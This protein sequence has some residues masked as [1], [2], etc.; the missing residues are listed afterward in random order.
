MSQVRRINHIPAYGLQTVNVKPHSLQQAIRA[1]V[2]C[3]RLVRTARKLAEERPKDLSTRKS[4]FVPVSLSF[5][6]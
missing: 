5:A 2:L 3:N 6:E 1:V 4:H